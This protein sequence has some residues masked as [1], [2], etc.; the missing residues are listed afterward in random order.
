MK[1]IYFYC[2]VGKSSQNTPTGKRGKRKNY[3]TFERG[4]I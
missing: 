4:E 2:K 1:K 3:I